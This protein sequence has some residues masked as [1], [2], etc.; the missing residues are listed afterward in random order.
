M[1]EFSDSTSWEEIK[2]AL[3]DFVMDNYFSQEF[4]RAVGEGYP[5]NDEVF[6][7]EGCFIGQIDWLL[8]EQ[9]RKFAEKYD[10]SLR[11]TSSLPSI[12][13]KT[14]VGGRHGRCWGL[15]AEEGEGEKDSF[16]PEL[17]RGARGHRKA[18]GG[19][20]DEGEGGAA[21]WP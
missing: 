6:D 10:H 9:V 18:S 8:F 20:E 1:L 7:E 3:Q 14:P 5:Y 11:E 12:H 16:N 13:N 17:R 21:R 19:R 4:G 2:G 15:W